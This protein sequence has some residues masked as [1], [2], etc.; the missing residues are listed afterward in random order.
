MNKETF[1]EFKE[2][3]KLLHK[4]MKIIEKQT[5]RQN[6]TA[7]FLKSNIPTIRDRI[8]QLEKDFKLHI[9]VLH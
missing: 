4:I 9:G 8:T 2:L 1:I 5:E 7:C 6:N 3:Y